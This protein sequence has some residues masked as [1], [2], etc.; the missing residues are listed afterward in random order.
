[1]VALKTSFGMTGPL[2]LGTVKGPDLG[3]LEPK[4]WE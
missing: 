1:M 3:N 4:G 2:T